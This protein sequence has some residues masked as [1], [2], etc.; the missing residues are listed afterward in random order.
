MRLTPSPTAVSVG[1]VQDESSIQIQI[2]TSPFF[3]SRPQGDVKGG[4]TQV[5]P[6]SRH[7]NWPGVYQG[8]VL[9]ICV[10][11][12]VTHSTQDREVLPVNL[13]V[14]GVH[15]RCIIRHP[16]KS[17]HSPNRAKNPNACALLNQ[18]A[19]R[20]RPADIGDGDG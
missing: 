15:G 3:S 20:T 5:I 14:N 9:V 16:G 7:S 1:T 11:C 12:R 10:S 17:A 4:Q 18:M 13:N 6:V 2:I 8:Q 19:R